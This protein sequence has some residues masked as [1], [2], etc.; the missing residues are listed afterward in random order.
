[1]P[2]SGDLHGGRL[3][4][5]FPDLELADGAAELESRGFLDVNNAP[6]WDT[7]V[8]FIQH[9]Q[10][11]WSHLISWVPREFVPLADAGIRV[12]PEECILWL[13][14]AEVDLKKRQLFRWLVAP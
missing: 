3:L 12:N 13:D 6:P 10:S 9:G 2:P 1:M 5:Y 11:N 14:E 8:A 4:I 7:W